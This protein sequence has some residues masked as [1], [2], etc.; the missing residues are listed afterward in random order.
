L[1]KKDDEEIILAVGTVEPRKNYDAVLDCFEELLRIRGDSQTKLVVV[2]AAGWECAHT[3]AR[4]SA[5]EETGRV[6]WRRSATD[7]ELAAWYKR[8]TVFTYLSLYEGFGYP[9]FEAALAEVPMVLSN[10]SSIGELWSGRALCVDPTDQAAVVRA[11]LEVLDGHN[12][13][14]QRLIRSQHEWASR[15]TWSKAVGEYV[16]QYIGSVVAA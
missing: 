11:W 1:P 14:R 4:L 12:D 13:F 16:E 3:I 6:V 15:F 2:G 10:R 5:L 9:P 7:G 8:A